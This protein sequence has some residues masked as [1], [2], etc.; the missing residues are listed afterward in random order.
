ML[1]YYIALSG[2]NK[3]EYLANERMWL[4]YYS[5]K[6]RNMDKILNLL[7]QARDETKG[8]KQH[9]SVLYLEWLVHNDIL[10]G[11]E[12]L[13]LKK[14]ENGVLDYSKST[15]DSTLLLL[16][17]Q[18]L[19]EEG[20]SQVS[21]KLLLE[22]S[23]AITQSM[24]P[25]TAAS[26]L[27]EKAD[28]ELE[29]RNFSRVKILYNAYLNVIVRN[30]TEEDASFEMLELANLYKR[31]DL[32]D[33]SIEVCKRLLKEFPNSEL[34]DDAAYAMALALKEKRSYSKAIKAFRN[35][36]LEFPESDLSK[37]AIKEVLS[38]FTV[39]GKG[40]RAEKTVSFL[41][42]IIAI[43]PHGDFSIM[44]RFELASSLVSLARREEAIREYQYIIDNYPDSDYANYSRRS[45]E[46]LATKP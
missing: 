16:Y 35:F 9:L 45:I 32:L 46:R 34:A 19:E 7:V 31:R 38:I 14:L 26:I 15:G 33:E 2:W 21:K 24:E 17:S 23:S 4:L 22:Y 20:E 25:A 30:Y 41:K 12:N 1:D 13:A 39:Y 36:I 44:A 18:L 10:A 29:K 3:L 11:K 5:E 43:Y 8:E 28:I 37:S 27:K 6:T 40:T 42:E